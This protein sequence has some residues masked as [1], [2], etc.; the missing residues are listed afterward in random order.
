[1]ST[2]L[3]QVEGV[4]KKFCRSLKRS[5][6]YGATDLAHELTG[7]EQDRAALRS[8]EFWAVDGVSFEVRPGDTLGLIGPNGAGKTTLL[9]ML[10]GLIRPDA[11]KISYCIFW[12]RLSSCPTSRATSVPDRAAWWVPIPAA[13]ASVPA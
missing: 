4:R 12:R 6:W 1:M 9:R 8:G 3:I 2:P 13:P 11:G 10:S 7:R 5:L